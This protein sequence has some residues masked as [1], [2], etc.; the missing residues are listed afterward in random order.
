M[1]I[2]N[3]DKGKLFCWP[4][5]INSD[6][7]FQLYNANLATL[8]T[9]KIKLAVLFQPSFILTVIVGFD[10]KFTIHSPGGS[11]V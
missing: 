7:N 10:M 11:V 9:L 2:S 5:D 1:V 8:L 6:E 4:S 3:L